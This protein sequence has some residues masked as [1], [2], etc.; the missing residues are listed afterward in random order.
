[1]HMDAHGDGKLLIIGILASYHVYYELKKTTT[2]DNWGVTGM[3]Y[4]LDL[5]SEILYIIGATPIVR[6]SAWDGVEYLYE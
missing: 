4:K 2:K 5:F 3:Q 6:Q 1:M